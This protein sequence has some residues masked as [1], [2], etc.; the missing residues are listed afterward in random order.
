MVLLLWYCAEALDLGFDWKGLSWYVFLLWAC[1]L[2]EPDLLTVTGGPQCG[3]ATQCG[4]A[5]AIT[6]EICLE[7][8]LL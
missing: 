1:D 3:P 5:V 4:R 6:H 2:L 7:T 8:E